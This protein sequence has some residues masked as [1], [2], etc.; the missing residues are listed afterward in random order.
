[1]LSV[2]RPKGICDRLGI[3]ESKLYEDFVARPG[4]E[5]ECIPGTN[6]P[7]LKLVVLGPRAVG[8]VSTEIDA[9]IMALAA[10]R[11]AAKQDTRAGMQANAGHASKAAAKKRA[12]AS[13][14]KRRSHP[15]HAGG[16]SI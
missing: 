9:L 6:V 2:I 5:E 1:M 13:R 4:D 8:A 14:R 3:G 11:D 16:K 12:E 10:E 15:E 7:K